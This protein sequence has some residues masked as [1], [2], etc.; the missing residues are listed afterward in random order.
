MCGFSTTFVTEVALGMERVGW[1]LRR[2][3]SVGQEMEERGMWGTKMRTSDCNRIEGN[4][5]W[6]L[7]GLRQS[8]PRLAGMEHWVKCWRSHLGLFLQLPLL[9]SV[10]P[11]F[12]PLE[13]SSL[14]RRWVRTG[15]TTYI[16]MLT[17]RTGSLSGDSPSGADTKGKTDAVAFALNL[18]SRSP[19]S[20][21][22]DGTEIIW[23]TSI[24]HWSEI[25]VVSSFSAIAL[26]MTLVSVQD[27]SDVP[28][29]FLQNSR[30]IFPQAAH[31][32][33]KYICDCPILSVIMSALLS[34]SVMGA[35][36]SYENEDPVISTWARGSEPHVHC[37]AHG[38]A[39]PA[40]WAH[41]KHVR[42]STLFSQV[43]CQVCQYVWQS[44]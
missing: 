21:N 31:Y 44:L 32:V 38:C 40:G 9:T 22:S 24:F 16:L 19:C 27:K 39:W 6:D 43:A 36:K 28:S 20:G 18:W 34:P 3:K 33:Y 2:S 1:R 7:Q 37:P 26:P 30:W 11:S 42:L 23:N 17:G 41:L 35:K 13:L 14:E 12:S 4:D 10:S 8:Q 15:D 5:P 25:L 29:S